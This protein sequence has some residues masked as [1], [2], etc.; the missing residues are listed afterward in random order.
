MKFCG[1]ETYRLKLLE[2]AH[3]PI[4]KGIHEVH[5]D[6]IKRNVKELALCALALISGESDIKFY[7]KNLTNFNKGNIEKSLNV[8]ILLIND[9]MFKMKIHR[10]C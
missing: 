2:T 7:Q 3:E 9:R 1:S 10:R 6:K 8:I 4:L 5:K